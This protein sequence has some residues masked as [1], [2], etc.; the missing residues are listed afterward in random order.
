MTNAPSPFNLEQE[1]RVRDLLQD[2]MKMTMIVEDGIVTGFRSALTP[3][4]EGQSSLP[5]AHEKSG[6]GR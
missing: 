6:D 3:Q 1:A 5:L 4:L 2:G